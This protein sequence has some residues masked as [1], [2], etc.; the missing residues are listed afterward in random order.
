MKC[1]IC[2]EDVTNS[3]ELQKHKGR[4]HPTDEDDT[5]KGETPDLL[6]DTPQE[7]AEIETPMRTY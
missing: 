1:D 4:I 2:G 6:G 7:S 3:E 5:G